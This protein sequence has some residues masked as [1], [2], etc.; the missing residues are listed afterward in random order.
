M[1]QLCYEDLYSQ[2]AM[3]TVAALPRALELEAAVVAKTI[4]ETEVIISEAE[5]RAREAY[6]A[7]LIPGAWLLGEHTGR[8]SASQPRPVKS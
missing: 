1:D 2:S 8:S 7:S 3:I 6:V 4:A 5:R